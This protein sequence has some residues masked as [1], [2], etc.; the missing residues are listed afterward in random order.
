[1]AGDAGAKAGGAKPRPGPKGA[2]VTPNVWSLSVVLL[3][4]ALIRLIR[5]IC[6]AFN[7]LLL[8]KNSPFVPLAPFAVYFPAPYC[9]E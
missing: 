2:A 6:N 7:L 9:R 3:D 1:M 4:I 5:R 8:L